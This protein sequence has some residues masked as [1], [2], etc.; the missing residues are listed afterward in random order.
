MTNHAVG[1]TMGVMTESAFV[2]VKKLKNEISKADREGMDDKDI[3]KF[4]VVSKWI[5][6]QVSSIIPSSAANI[7]VF[8]QVC[9][10]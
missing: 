3:R 4:D 8:S 5:Q 1:M 10:L 9:P 2:Q 7:C 6:G